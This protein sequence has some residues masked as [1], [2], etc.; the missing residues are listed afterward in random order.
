MA[1][2]AETFDRLA[3]D[4][5]ARCTQCGR[6]VEVCPTAAESGLDRS[7][8]ARLVRGLI[9]LARTGATGDADA[10]RWV[11]GCDASG[12][13]SAAC[14]EGINVRQWVSIAGARA[15]TATRPEADRQAAA[16]RRFRSMSH[17][18]R[19]LASMQMPSEALERILAPVERRRADLLFYTG[20]NV[21]RTSHIV[22]NVMDILEALGVDFDVVGGPAHCCGVYQF[23]EG[24]LATY[25]RVGGRTF[26]RFGRAG[27]REVA[28]WCPTCTKN[29][30]E[31]ERDRAGDSFGFDHI[32]VFLA[33]RLDAL[34]ARFV[35][36]PPR[37]AV[38]HEHD[39][40]AGTR[41][42]VRALLAAVPNLTLLELPQD[43]G[44]SYTCG[45]PAAAYEDRQTAIH[46][47]MAEGA[48]ALGADLLV[49]TYHSC[50]RALAGA[51]ARYPFRVVNFTDLLA[52][53]L[54][55]GGHTDF[56]KLYKSGGEMPE[57]VAAARRYLEGAGIKVSAESIA[58][59]GAEMF[60][61]TGLAGDPA[62]FTAALAPLTEPP[63]AA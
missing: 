53:A 45:G 12:Q 14:P 18:V 36:Q 5:A 56:F 40:I 20:C 39:G 17:A 61:E 7:E 6:C 60:A 13:C 59:L 4:A 44:F 46:R 16:A 50:H 11:M 27:A 41:E 28:T 32:S 48:K 15:R 43:S 1:E 23:M 30:S 25:D 38:I 10:S 42:S 31:I 22:F 52:E 63:P 49:T 26:E 37:K 47:N 33:A 3:A 57:A 2:L 29:F 51:E 54:G 62:D 19:L 34:R 55:R 21:L 24:D 9:E 35:Y 8:P 58:A